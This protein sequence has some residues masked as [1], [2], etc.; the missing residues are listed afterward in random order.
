[1]KSIAVKYFIL[2]NI[3]TFAVYGL[4]SS[5]NGASMS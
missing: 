4:N 5:H 3:A 2:L 1:M